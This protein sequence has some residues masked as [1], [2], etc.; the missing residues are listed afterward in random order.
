MIYVIRV[1]T[2]DAAKA[3]AVLKAATRAAEKADL[4]KP[5]G[6]FENPPPVPGPPPPTCG[7]GETC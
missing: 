6:T 4:P 2:A 5:V 3:L 7:P 1:Q